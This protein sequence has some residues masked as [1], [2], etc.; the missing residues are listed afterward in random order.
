MTV[1]HFKAC[2]MY[3]ITA[4][5][6]HITLMQSL[7]PLFAQIQQLQ[8][9]NFCVQLITFP[10]AS[11]ET[12]CSYST[13]AMVGNQW[14][15]QTSIMSAHSWIAKWCLLPFGSPWKQPNTRPVIRFNSIYCSPGAKA[16]CA[17]CLPLLQTKPHHKSKKGELIKG[18]PGYYNEITC[19]W[20]T[21][22]MPV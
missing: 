22:M 13:W 21:T 20:W 17:F 19:K 16:S 11:H 9:I 15:E 3:C 18:F 6:T 5:P 4:T 10:A 14:V 2:L 7:R 1:Q 12:S 8:S